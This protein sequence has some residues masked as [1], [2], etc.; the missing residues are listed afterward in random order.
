[1]HKA[2]I[3]GLRAFA[4]SEWLSLHEGTGIT[5][6]KYHLSNPDLYLSKYPAA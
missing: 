6:K 3:L 4:G 5:F 1:M 2:S